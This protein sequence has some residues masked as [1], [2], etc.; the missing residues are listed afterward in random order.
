MDSC[1]AEVCKWVRGADLMDFG[2]P[3][4]SIWRSL[5]CNVAWLPRRTH[6]KTPLK[7]AIQSGFIA[8]FSL[9]Q[10]KI[11][12]RIIRTAACFVHFTLHCLH[13][14]SKSWKSSLPMS[15][16]EKETSFLGFNR[17]VFRHYVMGRRREGV[18]SSGHCLSRLVTMGHLDFRT[19]S[20][21]GKDVKTPHR[22]GHHWPNHG[23]NPSLYNKL[24]TECVVRWVNHA[25]SPFTLQSTWILFFYF[26]KQCPQSN[27]DSVSR[28][29]GASIGCF[30][31]ML[32]FRLAL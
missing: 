8:L 19:Y 5:Q 11:S 10:V 22:K 25:H 29:F 3:F 2:D 21:T 9:I 16:V 27:N 32:W 30:H 4:F 18:Y 12:V 1:L 31:Y 6:I 13:F 23:S 15:T 20:S 28:P 24:T 17:S 26:F 14:V 7:K